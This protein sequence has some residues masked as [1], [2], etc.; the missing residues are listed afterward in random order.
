[1]TLGITFSAG[2]RVTGTDLQA[3]VDQIDSL[4]APGWTSYG[5]WSTLITA[6]TTNPTQ[7]SSTVAA[8]YR[9][10]ANSD[11]CHIEIN[12][13]IDTGG[14]F[15]AGSGSYRFL[16]P[17]TAST[18][19]QGA[20][21]MTINESGVALRSGGTNYVDTTHV[22]G[23]YSSAGGSI[24]SGGLSTSWTTGDWVKIAGFYRVA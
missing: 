10:P 24:G 14:G 1:M 6:S 5:T 21:H 19:E 12:L 3:M 18:S 22:E 2:N 11:I 20:M 8:Q 16:L 9:R 23:W 4:T 7:G 15:N 17:F 13:A